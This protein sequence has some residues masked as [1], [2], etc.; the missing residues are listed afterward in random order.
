MR[1]ALLIDDFR[2]ISQL[3]VPEHHVRRAK[4]PVVDAHTHLGFRTDAFGDATA[5]SEGIG[6]L[7]DVDEL[8]EVMDQCG[9]K[10][11]VN[12]S[13]RW[14][15]DLKRLL[16]QFEGRYPGRFATFCN[17]DWSRANE[18][19]FGEWAAGQLEESV[20]AGARG[21][22]IFKNLGLQVRDADG[23]LVMPDDERLAPIWD[24]AGELSVPVLIHV[25]DPVAFFTPLDRFNERWDELHQHPDW[26]FYHPQ[27]PT[28]IDL[29]EQQASL[30]AK[31]PEVTFQSAHVASY[32]ENLQWVGDLLDAHP[33]LTV[34]ISERIAELGRQPY[35]AREFCIKY[36]DRIVFG[37]DRPP[38]GP[39]YEIYFRFLETLDEYFPHGPE[40]PPRQGRWNIYGIG[41]PDEVLEKIYH[42]NAEKIYPR[43]A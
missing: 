13:G 37:T 30:L 14:G 43:L 39:W 25:A 7:G 2:P 33:N 27:Y 24:K 23:K 20:R 32:A 26:G 36:Q 11:M 9:V 38:M 17:L 41:L 12:L 22:K 19:R 28:F 31:H 21:L 1:D 29:M 16:D 6:W 34:D 5:P 3:V 15:D 4:F 35:T 42:K 10:A 18:A 8:A 40:Q